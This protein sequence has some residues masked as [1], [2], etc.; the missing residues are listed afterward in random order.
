MLCE[1]T[2]SLR[3]SNRFFIV[4]KPH[5]PGKPSQLLAEGSIL[6]GAALQLQ[7]ETHLAMVF[8]L[9]HR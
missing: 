1:F 5:L 7:P 2:G 6:L 4:A 8:H 9:R 3:E